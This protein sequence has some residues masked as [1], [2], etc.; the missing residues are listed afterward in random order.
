MFSKP[1]ASSIQVQSQ[2]NTLS[3][4]VHQEN[5]EDPPLAFFRPVK[6]CS[7]LQG[8]E[9]H[10]RPETILLR[11]NTTV[12]LRVTNL[13]L[14]PYEGK[15]LLRFALV[16]ATTPTPVS[17]PLC[18]AAALST[19]KKP[20]HLIAIDPGH[21]GIDP[22]ARGVNG[23]KEKNITLEMARILQEML[24]KKGYKVVLT[25]AKDITLRRIDRLK[26]I[27]SAKADLFI[28]V[29]A[30]HNP[31]KSMHGASI[32]T[33]APEASDPE[34]ARLAQRENVADQHIDGMEV[35]SPEVAHIL[36]DLSKRVVLQQAKQFAR[37]LERTLDEEDRLPFKPRRSADF[38]ILLSA[39]VP[40]VLIE[41]GY[42]SNAD[43]CKRLTS[44]V[45][46][47]KIAGKIVKAI[48]QYFVEAS[49]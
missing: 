27:E 20:L 45:F 33:L 13:S 39:T 42:L 16:P 10:R 23:E 48:E 1:I 38:L 32:Y 7:V 34:S 40:S 36:D 37:L 49:L 35:S 17:Q 47:H 22:G 6:I 25:R 18:A 4:T 15:F 28:S 3:L 14:T 19:S 21:G 12:P 31:E 43:D 9:I 5:P 11:F 44:K 46:L 2:K 29:H 24:Q 30:D 41:L 8:Y 26:K